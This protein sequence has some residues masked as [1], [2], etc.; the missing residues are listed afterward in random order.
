MLRLRLSMSAEGRHARMSAEEWNG[1]AEILRDALIDTDDGRLFFYKK[2]AAHPPES[3]P[4]KKTHSK[5]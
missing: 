5:E 2:L 4:I 3:I 1:A